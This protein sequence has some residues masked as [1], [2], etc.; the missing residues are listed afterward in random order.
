MAWKFPNLQEKNKLNSK[1]EIEDSLE[2][3]YTL[4][5]PFLFLVIKFLVHFQFEY[6]CRKFCKN[7]PEDIYFVYVPVTSCL[8]QQGKESVDLLSRFITIVIASHKE[9]F[10]LKK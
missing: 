4:Y 10:S 7:N 6:K 8:L 2:Y 5:S 9:G 3:L 1:V